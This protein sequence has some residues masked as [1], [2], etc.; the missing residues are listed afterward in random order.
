MVLISSPHCSAEIDESWNKK[1]K[2]SIRTFQNKMRDVDEVD[3][4][5]K[6]LLVK[7]ID[8]R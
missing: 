7:I 3:K 4:K 5:S 2:P 6:I 8:D 1:Q